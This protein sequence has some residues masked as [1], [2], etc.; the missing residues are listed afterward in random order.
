MTLQA[1]RR[2]CAGEGIGGG[3]GGTGSGLPLT[4][5]VRGSSKEHGAQPEHESEVSHVSRTTAW[6]A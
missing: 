1:S 5:R 4:A 3:S 6:P 2:D